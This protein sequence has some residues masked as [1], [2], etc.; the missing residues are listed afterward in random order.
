MNER[1]YAWVLARRLYLF[2][3]VRSTSGRS[4]T[5]STCVNT[6]ELSSGCLHEWPSK[7]VR[8]THTQTQT[9]TNFNSSRYR[10]ICDCFHCKQTCAGSCTTTIIINS[11][12]KCK[13]L[14]GRAKS[15]GMDA[16]RG[17]ILICTINPFK[18]NNCSELEMSTRTASV[19]IRSFSVNCTSIRL[20]SSQA[21]RLYHMRWMLLKNFD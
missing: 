14:F 13:R 2:S 12:N 1:L 19:C 21:H 5:R 7:L 17:N 4:R 11:N 6:F 3:R 18:I 15:S 10:S 20:H 9:H 8:N 16:I